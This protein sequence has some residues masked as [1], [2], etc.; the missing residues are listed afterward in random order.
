MLEELADMGFGWRDIARMVGVSVPSLRKWRSG[1]MPTGENRRSIA[2]LLAFV[3]II[4]DDHLVFGPAT[5]M[6]VPI[7]TDAPLTGIDLYSGG[8]LDAVFD[9]ATHNCTPGQ[10]LDAAVPDWRERFRSDWEVELGDDGQPYIHQK[11]ER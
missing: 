11:T 10:A 7:T 3:Q 6:E 1:D 8:H 5:W 4:R 2:Q 9:L